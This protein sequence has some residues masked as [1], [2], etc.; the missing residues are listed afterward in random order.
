MF[1]RFCSV[2]ICFFLW[3]SEL[4]QRIQ[5]KKKTCLGL[6]GLDLACEWAIIVSAAWAV[7]PR[8]TSWRGVWHKKWANFLAGELRSPAHLSRLLCLCH[9]PCESLDETYTVTTNSTHMTLLIL[10]TSSNSRALGKPWGS[11]G[12][13][14]G[15]QG[16]SAEQMRAVSFANSDTS[17]STFASLPPPPQTK[18]LPVS[19]DLNFFVMSRNA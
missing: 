15:C 13:A 17:L 14:L 5:G 18:K 16:T 2:F 11:P 1:F 19:K 9:S 12:E 10:C 7:K 4:D 6:L 3:R 8:E